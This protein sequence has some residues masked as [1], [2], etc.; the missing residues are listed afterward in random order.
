MIN[1]K[2]IDL[3]QFEAEPVM[4]KVLEPDRLIAGRFIKDVAINLGG[5]MFG[6]D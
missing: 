6:W 5:R 4:L 3:T 1:S 2:F